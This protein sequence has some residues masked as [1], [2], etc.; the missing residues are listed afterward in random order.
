MGYRY[1]QIKNLL[2]VNKN[3]D[4]E[5]T[6]EGVWKVGSS[7]LACICTEKKKESVHGDG[8]GLVT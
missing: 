6:S 3:G 5:Q 7:T 1:H 4:R 2:V 8:E